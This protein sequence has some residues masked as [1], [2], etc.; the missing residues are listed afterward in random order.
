VILWTVHGFSRVLSVQR[1]RAAL[2]RAVAA[3]SIQ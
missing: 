3:A 2:A 1:I